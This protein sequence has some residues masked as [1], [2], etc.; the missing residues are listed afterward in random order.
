MKNT[1]N[2]KYFE[3]RE[4]FYIIYSD[5]IKKKS[6]RQEATAKAYEIVS[7][8]F[9][10]SEKTIRNILTTSTRITHMSKNNREC[11]IQRMNTIHAVIN[12]IHDEINKRD[13]RGE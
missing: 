6:S 5:E 3:I 13:M 1:T 11:F 2:Q 9:H 12:K 4:I 8:F 7:Q 10:I